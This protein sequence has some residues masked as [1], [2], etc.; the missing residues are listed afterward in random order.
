MNLPGKYT[1]DRF[2]KEMAVLLFRDDETREVL[3]NR[4]SLPSNADEG[5]IFFIEFNEDDSVQQIKLL[6]EETQATR[7][8]VED[9]L[10]KLKK[11]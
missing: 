5:D 1:L 7:Q 3:I 8:K 9:L 4:K 10:N 6:E 11:K 2:E